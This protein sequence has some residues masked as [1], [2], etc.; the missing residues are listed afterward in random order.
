[1]GRSAKNTAQ[2]V[3]WIALVAAGTAN[4][5]IGIGAESLW[6]DEAYSACMIRNGFLDIVGITAGDNHPPLYYLGLKLWSLAFGESEAALRSFSALGLAC[7]SILGFFPVRRLAGKWA[8]MAFSVLV[9]TLSINVQ[10]AQEAR[11]YTWLEL[12]CAGSFVH[13]LL[14]VREGERK[15][16]VAMGAYA[17]CACYTHYYGLFAAAIIFAII[18]CYS[19]IR[20]RDRL[21][22][23]LICCGAV[24]VA[25]APWAPVLLGRTASV[26]ADYWIGANGYDPMAMLES[27]ARFP[28]SY[29]FETY[30]IADT[31]RSLFGL[32][33]LPWLS[34]GVIVVGA[35]I[36]IFKRDNDAGFP[37]MALL[38]WALFV[39][40]AL[41]ASILIRPVYVERYSVAVIGIAV[42]AVALAATSIRPLPVGLGI[43]ALFVAA[44]IPNH[45]AMREYRFNGM[46]R[47]MA[48]RLA[49]R[50]EDYGLKDAA[51]LHN[52]EHALGV[53]SYY[54][55]RSR[56][57]LMNDGERFKGY[58]NYA[59]FGP[60]AQDGPDPEAFV[61]ESE[62]LVIVNWSRLSLGFY[63]FP[64]AL[65]WDYRTRL[66][67]LPDYRIVEGRSFASGPG[68]GIL[69]P[70]MGGV[71]A[72]A[73][74]AMKVSPWYGFTADIYERREKR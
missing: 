57:Y 53:F 74:I 4:L 66:T 23:L 55:P 3:V 34:L 18:L 59:A 41:L 46:G 28:F 6:Y 19:L 51:F 45:L 65:E 69:P 48:E 32:P 60:L 33:L 61:A 47:E 67:S 52:D 5:F 26:S 16:I 13:G 20:H 63:S 70:G 2:L 38:A 27:S 7:L 30:D 22:L 44:S 42:F 68:P 73:P 11:M 29:K 54:F 21:P 56:H 39:G 10:M 1:M 24:V 15:D 43:V 36:R 64:Y 71:G 40:G 14:A 12:F 31:G 9:L 72:A 49:E 62:V 25:F 37:L 8:G 50:L 17:A 58:S 35:S